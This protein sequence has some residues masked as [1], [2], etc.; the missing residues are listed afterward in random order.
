MALLLTVEASARNVLVSLRYRDDG[1]NDE[2]FVDIYIAYSRHG[3]T[4]VANHGHTL[5]SRLSY[6]ALFLLAYPEDVSGYDGYCLS[7][8]DLPTSTEYLLADILSKA[9]WGTVNLSYS[10]LLYS[11]KSPELHF[12]WNISGES[13]WIFQQPMTIE[14]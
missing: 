10:S 8:P 13:Q 5:Q 9:F 11:R 14:L 7:S 1:H 12:L 3:V 4:E 6:F 2:K